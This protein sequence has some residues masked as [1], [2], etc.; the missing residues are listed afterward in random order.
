LKPPVATTPSKIDERGALVLRGYFDT[1]PNRVTYELD[2]IPSETEWKLLT[3]NV[4]V[5]AAGPS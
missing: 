2:F 3:I 5:K 4:N 1:S